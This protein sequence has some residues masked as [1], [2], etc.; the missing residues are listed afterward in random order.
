MLLL[1][2]PSASRLRTNS[3]WIPA[4]NPLIVGVMPV[5][6]V[7]A[8][9]K[10]WAMALPKPGSVSKKYSIRVR[11]GATVGGT[12]RLG[13]P[14][15]Y[16]VLCPVAVKY[17]LPVLF[18]AFGVSTQ[19]SVLLLIRLYNLKFVAGILAKAGLLA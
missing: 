10:L 7:P 14:I 2:L 19:P 18:I 13:P 4:D 5:D 8:A 6:T 9:V 3:V 1:H 17:L 16:S 11:F 12:T 15:M